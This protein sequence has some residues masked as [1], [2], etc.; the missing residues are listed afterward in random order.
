M[1]QKRY[2]KRTTI[3]TVSFISFLLG[4]G[5]AR[6][7][8]ELSFTALV[9]LFILTVI[10]FK[11]KKWMSILSVT[12]LGFALGLWRGG[13]YMNTIEPYANLAGSEVVFTAT[14]QS[15]AVYGFQ[16][17]LSFDADDISLKEPVTRNLPGKIAILGRGENALYRGDSVKVSGTLSNSR[18]SRQARVSFATIEIIE[19]DDSV[20]ESARRSFITGILNALPE[21][22]ASFGL[23]LLIGYRALLPDLTNE[24]LAITG[25]THIIAVSGYNLTVIVRAIRRLLKGISKYQQTV[26]SIVLILLFLFVTDFSASIVRASI[27]SS[28]SLMAWYYGRR[29]KPLLILSLTGALT[30]GWYPVYIWSDIGWYLSF[31]AFFGILILAPMTLRILYAKNKEPSQLMQLL[32]ETTAAQI[33][34]AP[35]ILFIFSRVSLVGILSNLIIA[36]LVP[37]AMVL[38][39]IAGIAGMFTPVLAGFIAWPARIVLRYILDIVAIFAS[40][41]YAML[42]RS[43]SVRYMVAMYFIIG[44]FTGLAWK[45]IKQKYG[46][47]T[48]RDWSI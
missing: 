16:G 45:N 24:Q 17:Q 6:L 20:L 23:G 13:S 10:T 28:L 11:R 15:D 36:P 21:P 31:L 7:Y 26:F 35:L 33:M 48:D 22:S 2:F 37:L 32:I 29:I 42:E 14:V 41:P 40:L 47:I 4:L 39:L 3:L 38:T 9:P 46:T 1:K 43:L 8:D 34:T 19:R 25:L 18:G 5:C 27:V 44:A 12:L 30:A